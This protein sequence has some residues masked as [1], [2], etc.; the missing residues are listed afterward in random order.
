MGGVPMKLQH[1]FE[2]NKQADDFVF[3]EKYTREDNP[4]VFDYSDFFENE[5]DG[6]ILEA[7]N[8]KF[9]RSTIVFNKTYDFR[10]TKFPK[11]LK[12]PAFEFQFEADNETLTDFK[13]F[14][15]INRPVSI[16]VGSDLHSA[17][18]SIHLTSL[19]GIPQTSY[20][21]L[22]GS[23]LTSLEHCEMTKPNSS[24]ETNILNI[25]YT[26][27][28][29]FKGFKFIGDTSD[30]EIMAAYCEKL[31]LEGIP[32][33][34]KRLDLI[35][36]SIDVSTLD[37]IESLNFIRLTLQPG[38]LSQLHEMIVDKGKLKDTKFAFF[39]NGVELKKHIKFEEMPDP[40][41]FQEWC[42]ENELDEYL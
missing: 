15:E 10:T 32:S 31:S 9:S 11:I 19:E 18:N 38:L 21:D 34:F 16:I 25:A 27:I 5:L 8:L 20:L 42:I 35:G 14:G 4:E 3:E 29:S 33:S 28:K 37:N 39:E 24:L 41:E 23:D 30:L 13:W 36:T 7:K 17:F 40:F 1:L 26:K 12:V 2:V 22:D 6:S